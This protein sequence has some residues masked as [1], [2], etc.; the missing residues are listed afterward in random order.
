[1]EGKTNFSKRL[2]VWWLDL[3]DPDP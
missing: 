2:T 1:M 3:P